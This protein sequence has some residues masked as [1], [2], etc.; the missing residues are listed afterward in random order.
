VNS[1]NIVKLKCERKVNNNENDKND[2]SVNDGVIKNR[3]RERERERE[4]ES[5]RV[6]ERERERETRKNKFRRVNR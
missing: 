6:C 2:G 3:K 5:V 4:R 1:F